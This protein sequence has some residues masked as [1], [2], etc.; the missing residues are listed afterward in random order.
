MLKGEI[1][2]LQKPDYITWEQITEL[3][4]LAFAEKNERGLKYLAT[5][6]DAETTR[7]RVGDGV[8][9][10]AL[11]GDVLIGTASMRILKPNEINKKWHNQNLYAYTSQLAVHP[12]YKG[13]GVG[14]LLQNARI[15]YCHENNVD[16]MLGHTS[17][18]AK[19]IL[20]WYRRQG[21]DFVEYISSPATNYYA[22]RMRIPIKGKIFNSYY[23]AFRYYLS[24]IKCIATK[25]K[26]GKIR[27]FWRILKKNERVH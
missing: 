5:H 4:H 8:C 3:L 27:F 24:V 9:F 7:R 26:Y 20:N 10:V 18:H 11:L 23:V 1:K 2:I 21:A 12:D 22:V 13:Y 6:Q 25:D 19:E 17:I 15:M 16:E 14:K